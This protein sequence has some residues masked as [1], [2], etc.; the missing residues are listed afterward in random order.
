METLSGRRRVRRTPFWL[1]P[2]K[3]GVVM[4]SIGNWRRSALVGPSQVSQKPS[5]KA[6]LCAPPGGLRVGLA[7]AA[8]SNRLGSHGRSVSVDERAKRGSGGAAINND[9]GASDEG[10]AG[11]GIA[12][13]RKEAGLTV[14]GLYKHFN[15]RDDLVVEAVSSTFFK[16]TLPH[17]AGRSYPTQSC[18]A[19]SA[20]GGARSGKRTMAT[21]QIRNDI[22]LAGLLR[23]RNDKDQET[24]QDRKAILVFQARLSA[25]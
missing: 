20:P 9:L 17:P 4:A 1:S 13:F 11:I 21:E 15:S 10:L 8:I 22:E 24:R 19:F 3:A 14:G 2:R 5:Q 25:P 16:W 18:C 12:G 7:F 6:E 23:A